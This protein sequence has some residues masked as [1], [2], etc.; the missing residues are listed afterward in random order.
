M[1]IYSILLC[2]FILIFMSCQ[3]SENKEFATVNSFVGIWSQ[4]LDSTVT[5]KFTE[6]GFYYDSRYNKNSDD[7]KLG[8]GRLDGTRSEEDYG[9]LIYKIISKDENILIVSIYGEKNG[10]EFRRKG[11]LFEK[12]KNTFIEVVYKMGKGIEDHIQYAVRYVK[13]GHTFTAS[14]KLQDSL[15]LILPHN[16]DKEFIF[17]A[18]DQNI[19]DEE[20]ANIKNDRKIHISNEGVNRISLREDMNV[21]LDGAVFSYLTD[22]KG[23]RN[24]LYTLQANEWKLLLEQSKNNGIQKTEYPIS[25]DSTV[26]FSSCS[27]NPDRKYV[28]KTFGQEMVGNI[29]NFRYSSIRAELGYLGIEE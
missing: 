22:D 13:N 12:G 11:Y 24:S 27:F 3:S 19:E 28:N 16:F 14:S 9:R 26:I 5:M 15:V 17:I 2:T 6:E 20:V 21:F 8:V 7:F 4:V 23:A 29:L 1:K 18:F 25:I 10:V